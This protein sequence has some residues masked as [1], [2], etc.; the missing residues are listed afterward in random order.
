MN[1]TNYN[2]TNSFWD[3]CEA[4]FQR[5]HVFDHTS[6][7][8]AANSSFF[9]KLST[10][11]QNHLNLLRYT[12]IQEQ[13]LE[14]R[15][16]EIVSLHA[17]IRELN[18]KITVLQAANLRKTILNDQLNRENNE[19]QAKYTQTEETMEAV[20]TK[21]HDVTKTIDIACAILG[22]SNDQTKFLEQ[23]RNLKYDQEK[24]C[25]DNINLK[26]EVKELAAAL[27][28]QKELIGN[29]AQCNH[30]SLRQSELRAKS[31][32]LP[33]NQYLE[34]VWHKYPPPQ[35]FSDSKLQAPLSSEKQ[36]IRKALMYYHPDKYVHYDSRVKTIA[37][38]ICQSLTE[39]L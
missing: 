33:L 14:S 36:L 39:K 3:E 22:Q 29:N 16:D 5:Q 35:S 7:E 12:Q 11:R 30:N 6:E 18:S 21:L 31:R 38:D 4:Y 37:N 23:L 28:L 34:W 32:S 1:D 19:M 27:K 13:K 25:S 15:M 8:Y 26:K 17:T 10:H 20:Q 2:S 9:Q 24:Q